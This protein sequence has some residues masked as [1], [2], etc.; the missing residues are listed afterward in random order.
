MGNYPLADA[1]SPYRSSPRHVF[2]EHF[3]YYLARQRR[4]HGGEGELDDVP[5]LQEIIR[6]HGMTGVLI[7]GDLFDT[8]N[9]AG[10]AHANRVLANKKTGPL[11]GP[12]S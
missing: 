12:A 6:R 7:D 10:Y 8:G 3:Y 1:L 9:P 4:D 5:V 2:N 11:T